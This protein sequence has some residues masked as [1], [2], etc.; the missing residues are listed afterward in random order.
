MLSWL[1]EKRLAVRWRVDT[2]VICAVAFGLGVRVGA[3]TRFVGRSL[4]FPGAAGSLRVGERVSVVSRSEATALG[5]SRP[6]ILRCLT[7][8]GR[9]DIGDDTGLSGTV[10][11]AAVGVTIGRRCR[12]GADV[13]IFDTDFHPHESEGRRY[14]VPNWPRIS[15][16]VRIGDDVFIGTG[17]VVQKGV[18]IGDGS[19]IAARSVVTKDVPPRTVAC[20]NPNWVLHDTI[21]SAA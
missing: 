13:T 7:P 8:E 10:V 2:F 16:P 17:S 14:A 9:I 5:V 1:R 4:L 21:A 3:G 11:C 6:V 20:G 12:M 15:A 19:I 18:T